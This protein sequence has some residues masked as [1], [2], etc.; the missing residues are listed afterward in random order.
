MIDTILWKTKLLALR[1]ETE[2]A[3][4]ISKEAA[5]PVTLD[6]ALVGRLSRIDALQQQE[7]AL[8]AKRRRQALIQQI[9]QALVRLEAGN[10]GI[11]V[12]CDEDIAETRL[13]FN[14][15]ILTCVSCAD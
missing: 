14:P 3:L 5:A 6:Q 4:Q 1:D 13:A 9:D 2:H 10:F 11:C 8:A 15:V 12:K 7:M